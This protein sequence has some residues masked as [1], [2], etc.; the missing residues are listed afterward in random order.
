MRRG[1]ILPELADLLDLPTPHG[2]A[3]LLV[4][5]VRAKFT[6]QRPAPHTGAINLELEA[7]MNFVRR[8]RIR[9]RRASLQ[10]FG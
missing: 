8:E 9:G 10:K 1:V 3:R 5:G 6:G 2:F 7:A 4:S